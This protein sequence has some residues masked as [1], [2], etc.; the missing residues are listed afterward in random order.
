MILWQEHLNNSNGCI[1][2][3]ETLKTQGERQT[4]L[5]SDF[6]HKNQLSSLFDTSHEN[7][8]H[9]ETADTRLNFYKRCFSR[10]AV[11]GSKKDSF[12]HPLF[13]GFVIENKDLCSSAERVDVLVYINSAVQNRQRRRA[14][15]HS[16]ASQNAFTGVTI[17]LV[18]ILGQPAS[19]REQLEIFSEHA[20]SGDIVQA[21]FEDTFRNLTFKAVTFMAWANAHCA[22]AQYVVKVDDDMFVDMFA[23]IFKIIPKMA[24]KSYAMACSYT[25][26]GKISRNPKSN[27]YVGKTL[28]AGQTHYPGFCP[29]F[30]S[31]ITGNIIPE[32]Y[33]GSFAV[34]DH[35]PIDDVYMTSLSLRNPENVS[36]IDIR[37]QLY[38]NERSDPDQE[39][40]V[41]GHFEYIAFRVKEERQH[42]ALWN[43][44]LDK[45]SS[46]EESFSSFTHRFAVY[47]KQ[48]VVIKK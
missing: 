46:L 27:W 37:D 18:F 45:V 33:E 13:T 32:L 29:G 25:K 38:P 19:R 22:Q 3:L 20:S 16:W 23:V 17:R 9:K 48:S 10:P 14:I 6:L 5:V 26:H 30:F 42:M 34:K 35:I 40:K 15:R 4:R 43:L 8:Y 36:I 47:E 21:K 41:N 7:S 24:D 2:T 1:N 44:R 31:V 12:D 28:L 39:I 11:N